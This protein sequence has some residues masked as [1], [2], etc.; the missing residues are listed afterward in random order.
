M[1]PYL[2]AGALGGLIAFVLAIPAMVLEIMHRGTQENLPLVID[3]KKVFGRTLNRYE[4][5]EAAVFL[6]VV[7]GFLFG[8]VYVLFVERGWLVVTHAPFTF[9]SLLVYAV[10]AFI[11]VGAMIFPALG[12]GWFGRKEGT[13]VW[14][15]IL[16]SML[17]NG[18][19]LWLL[20][21]WFSPWFF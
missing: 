5:F 16:I 19:G 8:V 11:V 3:V 6:H 14:L 7:L 13:R 21:R 17:C 1:T 4:I 10:G 18:I 2:L 12:M 9:T 15:E 20:V